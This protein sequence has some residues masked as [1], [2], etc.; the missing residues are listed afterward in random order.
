MPGLDAIRDMQNAT[1]QSMSRGP[2]RNAGAAMG[3]HD[4]L[5]LL[6]AQLRHQDPLDPQ[7]DSDFA[8]SLAQF[9]S[10]EQMMNM[11]ESLTSMQAFGLVGQYVVATTLISGRLMEIAGVVDSVFMSDGRKFAQI[12]EYAVPVDDISEVF[13]G[14]MFPSPQ[15]LLRASDNLLDRIVEAQI[16]DTVTIEGV[17]RGVEVRNGR[18]HALVELP[19]GQTHLVQVGA[20]F[21]IR[22]TPTPPA[23]PPPEIPPLDVENTVSDGNGGYIEMDDDGMPIYHWAW[24]AEEEEWA[25]TAIPPLDVDNTA[26]DGNGGK[27]QVDDGGEPIYLWTWNPE[28][29]KWESA[30]V[31][32]AP[33]GDDNGDDSNGDSGK[34]D[35]DNK[36][37]GDGGASPQGNSLSFSSMGQASSSYNNNGGSF[38]G[39]SGFSGVA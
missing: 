33:P 6:S 13:D 20:I 14:S 34:V 28:D 24:D 15:D 1:A 23:P 38:G 19:S 35:D 31:G 27:V 26:P 16:S 25:S 11:S 37:G 10:L 3:K 9:A 21:N 12:G 18:L 17:V 22:S 32:A 29:G 7:S 30:P 8:T 36:D 2:D 39:G 4:F 5:L